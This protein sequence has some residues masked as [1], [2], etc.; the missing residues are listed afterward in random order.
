MSICALIVWTNWLPTTLV[1]S[2]VTFFTC[3]TRDKVYGLSLQSLH[4]KQ[5]TF[6]L[7][8]TQFNRFWWKSDTSI[9]MGFHWRRS[10]KLSSIWRCHN[11]LNCIGRWS[12]TIWRPS[13]IRRR[14]SIWRGHRCSGRWCGVVLFSLQKK[15]IANIAFVVS[16]KVNLVRYKS[17]ASCF[18][19]SA[20]DFLAKLCIREG[21]KFWCHSI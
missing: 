13:C 18:L 2:W 16:Q 10:W 14:S 20:R 8:V 12:W 9:G 4:W 7:I 5:K 17:L 15:E 1:T 6:F 3:S 21:T 19:L 11:S